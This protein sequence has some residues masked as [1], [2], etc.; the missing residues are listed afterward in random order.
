MEPRKD[1][2]RRYVVRVGRAASGE[3]RPRPLRAIVR[4]SPKPMIAE[5]DHHAL[6]VRFDDVID[7]LEDARVEELQL[8]DEPVCQCGIGRSDMI[9][10]EGR[11]T[12]RRR[13][14][15][16][17]EG[18]RVMRAKDVVPDESLGSSRRRL[19]RVERIEDRR[20]IRGMVERSV[21][22]DQLEYATLN[23]VGF[24]ER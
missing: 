1:V 24:E 13:R 20:A 17:R 23:K 22:E 19:E 2:D 9:R 5:D 14:P 4:I 10:A 6:R 18:V 8:P 16:G 12:R 15:I 11:F 3:Q 21:R 7:R